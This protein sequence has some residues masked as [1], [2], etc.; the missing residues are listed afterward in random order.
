MKC[1]QKY[2]QN[3]NR[4]STEYQKASRKRM[5]CPLPHCL[6]IGLSKFLLGFSKIICR[7]SFGE[8]LFMGGGRLLWEI[9]IARYFFGGKKAQNERERNG[10]SVSSFF[11]MRS[12]RPFLYWFLNHLAAIQKW[13]FTLDYHKKNTLFSRLITSPRSKS[14]R[15]PSIITKRIH[16]PNGWSLCLWIA[17]LTCNWWAIYSIIK[18]IRRNDMRIYL[19]DIITVIRWT[20]GKE[21]CAATWWIVGKETCAATWWSSPDNTVYL[22]ERKGNPHACSILRKY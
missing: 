9:E 1:Q 22:D 16:F 5:I 12:D 20:I 10:F 11:K 14:G 2:Q 6:W 21:T 3:I 17:G 19:V 18:T 8:Q 15:S 4:I 7:S 13:P